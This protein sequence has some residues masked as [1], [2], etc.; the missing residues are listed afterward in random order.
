MKHNNRINLKHTQSLQTNEGLNVLEYIS[1]YNENNQQIL[2]NL[3]SIPWYQRGF[4]EICMIQ[5]L[6]EV[7]EK[8]RRRQGLVRNS[9]S[10]PQSPLSSRL[11]NSSHKNSK[12]DLISSSSSKRSSPQRVFS[13]EE[14]DIHNRRLT[15]NTL[16]KSIESTDRQIQS[17]QRESHDL[18][19]EIKNLKSQA[20]TYDRY[21]SSIERQAVDLLKLSRDQLSTL[22]KRYQEEL[23]RRRLSQGDGHD[24]VWERNY[25]LTKTSLQL[26]LMVDREQYLEG[27]RQREMVYDPRAA[28]GYSQ[29]LA[30]E[31][32]SS[33]GSKKRN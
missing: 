25:F 19:E 31:R 21:L 30:D 15:R 22:R 24:P 6:E 7:I 14:R 26:Q 23:E 8:Q 28:S 29:C 13:P 10:S 20:I 1:E 12:K 11:K 18:T 4:T 33:S 3:L 9:S 27:I 5:K 16:K 17:L 2:D 32:R